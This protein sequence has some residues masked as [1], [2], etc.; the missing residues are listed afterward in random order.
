MC[1]L[2][3]S[4]CAR[5]ICRWADGGGRPGCVGQL[6]CEEAAAALLVS[7]NA[8]GVSWSIRH[9]SLGWNLSCPLFP[10]CST[11][12]ATNILLV[13]EIMRAGMSSLKGWRSRPVKLQCW[14]EWLFSS[15]LQVIWKLIFTSWLEKRNRTFGT[16]SNYNTVKFYFILFLHWVSKD[17]AG[18]FKPTE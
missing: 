12:I 13:D 3:Q 9:R 16:Y 10:P 5:V 8:R 11:V 2:E 1:F 6:L 17:K 4:L 14:G 18:H 15:K 7:V